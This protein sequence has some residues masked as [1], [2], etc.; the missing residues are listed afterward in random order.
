MSGPDAPNNA[1]PKHHIVTEADLSE[2]DL[3]RQT[4]ARWMGVL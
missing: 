1:C 3:R 4:S 2:V